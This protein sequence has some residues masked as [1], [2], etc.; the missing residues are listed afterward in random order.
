MY[1]EKLK[2]LFEIKNM[3]EDG[4]GDYKSPQLHNFLLLRLPPRTGKESDGYLHKN[5]YHHHNRHFLFI[6]F[7]SHFGLVL[8]EIV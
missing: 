3:Y 2:D 7:L 6:K 4:G 5:T 1:D 8:I